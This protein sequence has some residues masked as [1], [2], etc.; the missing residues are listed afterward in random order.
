MR[1]TLGIGSFHAT[2]HSRRLVVG[3]LTVLSGLL[4]ASCGGDKLTGPDD[5]RVSVAIVSGSG[6]TGPV[7][8]ERPQPLVVKVVNALGQVLEKKVVNFTVVSG[9]GSV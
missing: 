4:I 1:P 9:G 7:G 8:V 6:Q 2:S 5:S 3:S